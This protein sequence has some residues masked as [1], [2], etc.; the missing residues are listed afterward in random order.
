MIG[1]TL[2]KTHSQQ[3]AQPMYVCRWERGQNGVVSFTWKLNLWCPSNIE[4]PKLYGSNWTGSKVPM[5]PPDYEKGNFNGLDI[6]PKVEWVV[7]ASVVRA[8]RVAWKVTVNATLSMLSSRKGVL[9]STKKEWVRQSFSQSEEWKFCKKTSGHI[10]DWQPT[11]A[12]IRC[13]RASTNQCH[14]H[15]SCRQVQ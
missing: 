1:G 4:Y 8:G 15:H 6:K 9:F 12:S 7:P 2:S 13:C 11:S 5:L 14:H 10:E 3:T